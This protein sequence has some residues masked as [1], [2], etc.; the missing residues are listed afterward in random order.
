M[1]ARYLIAHPIA[2][3]LHTNRGRR[4]A[5]QRARSNLRPLLES[6]G[7]IL[8][9]ATVGSVAVMVGAWGLLQL[10]EPRAT[11]HIATAM[12]YPASQALPR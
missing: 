1:N 12:T 10:T 6:V 4:V 11:H 8:A 2:G 7:W 9:G 3:D 5:L